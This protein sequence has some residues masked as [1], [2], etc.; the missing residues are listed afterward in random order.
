MIAD[1]GH[2]VGVR[3]FSLY[4]TLNNKYDELKNQACPNLYFDCILIVPEKVHLGE[5]L[6]EAFEHCFYLSPCFGRYQQLCW[7]Q[8]QCCW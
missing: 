6:L 5:G 7:H 4:L 1:C 8:A 2:H 3:P